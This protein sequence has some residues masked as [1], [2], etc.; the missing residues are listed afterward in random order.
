[1]IFGGRK[2]KKMMLGIFLLLLSSW[3]LVFGIADQFA[4]ILYA[5]ILLLIASIIVFAVGYS[6]FDKK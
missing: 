5:S 2:M 4:P 3:G 6:D 1:M